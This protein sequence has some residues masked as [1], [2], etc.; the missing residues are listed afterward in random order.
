MLLFFNSIC[1]LP[2]LHDDANQLLVDVAGGTDSAVGEEEGARQA[3]EG[4]GSSDSSVHG[5][6]EIHNV[7]VR[8]GSQ[9]EM[10]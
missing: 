2:G 7:A 3:E 1:S 8:L 6:V 9:P 4:V 10:S 5:K